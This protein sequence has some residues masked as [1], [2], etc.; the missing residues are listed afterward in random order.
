MNARGSITVSLLVLLPLLLTALSVLSALYII[1]K[2]DSVSRHVCRVTLLSAQTNVANDLANL[3]KLNPKARA[4]RQAR[5]IAEKAR[6][7]AVG[8]KRVAAEAALRAVIVKQNLL[9]AEQKRLISKAKLTSR[10]APL[11]ARREIYRS[12]NQIKWTNTD[13]DLNS[14]SSSRG[15][16]LNTEVQTA[17]FDVTPEPKDSLTPDY[18]PSPEFSKHQEMTI[19]WKFDAIALLPSWLQAFLKTSAL[20]AKADCSATLERPVVSTTKKLKLK[21]GEKWVAKLKPGKS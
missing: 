5:E 12:L 10:R 14:N 1:L 13:A 4:L 3:M 19:D 9:A 17:L 15:F 2:A 8:P 7:F 20:E 21:G 16:R 11:Q 6:L 18:L